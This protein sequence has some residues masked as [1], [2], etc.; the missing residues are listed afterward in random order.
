MHNSTRFK[1]CFETINLSPSLFKLFIP[2]SKAKSNEHKFDKSMKK[3]HL[4][5]HYVIS[6]IV[7]VELCAKK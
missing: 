5:V 2:M 3:N 7:P 1:N 6:G 4:T